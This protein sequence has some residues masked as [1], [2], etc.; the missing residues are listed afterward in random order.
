MTKLTLS[1]AKTRATE[2]KVKQT[3]KKATIHLMK[4]AQ[5]THEASFE[6]CKALVKELFSKINAIS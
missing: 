4:V 5:T 6:K 3:K 1:E 2:G